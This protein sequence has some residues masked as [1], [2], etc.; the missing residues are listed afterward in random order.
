MASL[1]GVWQAKLAYVVAELSCG[2]THVF[3][4]THGGFLYGAL[5][6]RAC[7]ALISIVALPKRG[8][9]ATLSISEFK[10]NGPWRGALDVNEAHGPSMCLANMERDGEVFTPLP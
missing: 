2:S 1:A 7:V 8:L 10:E 5:D 3:A 4:R 9:P 6:R